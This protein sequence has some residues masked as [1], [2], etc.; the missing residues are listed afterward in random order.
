MR[1]ITLPG[2]Q[3][4][5]IFTLRQLLQWPEVYIHVRK[6]TLSEVDYVKFISAF[7][8]EERARLIAHQAHVPA[9]ECG[10]SRMHFSTS[11]RENSN[12]LDVLNKKHISTSTH[13]WK[14]FNNLPFYYEAAFVSPLF[15][16]ISKVGYGRQNCVAPIGRRNLASKAIALGG[17][18]STQLATMTAHNFDDFAVCGAMWEA[19][20]PISEAKSC[21]QLSKQFR[22]TRILII[23]SP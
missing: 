3:N 11:M 2:I 17:I 14:E 8:V 4:R 13:S 19:Q 9:L 20:D 18:S 16:S 5:E 21:L 6:P 10:L 1:I 12:L 7:S 15:P 23:T 22:D